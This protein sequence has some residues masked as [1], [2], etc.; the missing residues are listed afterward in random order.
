[1]TEDEPGETLRS[2]RVD[3]TLMLVGLFLALAVQNVIQ[4]VE[5]TSP[6][7]SPYFY[8]TIG[9]GSL[10]M[11]LLFVARAARIAGLERK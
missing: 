7:V 8:L 1:M 6:H 3:L 5:T 2:F 9:V 10:L 4:Y 11:V